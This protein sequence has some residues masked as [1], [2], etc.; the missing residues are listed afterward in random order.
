[1]NML[2]SLQTVRGAIEQARGLPNRF[3]TDAPLFEEEKRRIFANGWSGIGFA[4][5]VP[6]P[7]CVLPIDFLGTPLLAVR[8]SDNHL[9][10]FQNVCRHRGMILV[11]EKARLSKLI[12][13]PYHSWSYD[14]SGK[15][16]A[17]PHVGGS[18]KHEHPAICKAD[19]GLHE[20]RSREF[21]GVIFVNLSG[22]A[23]PFEEHAKTLMTRWQDFDKPLHS[24]GEAGSLSWQV[25]CNWKLVVENY[26]ESYHLPFIH[27]SLNRYSRLEDH[28][29]IEHPG[30]FSGQG[31]RVYAP[32]LTEDGRRL[33]DFPGVGNAWATKGEYIA[34][35]PN[36]LFGVHRDHA[37]AMLLQ[38]LDCGR[39][40]ERLELFYAEDIQDDELLSSN[41][42]LWRTV[43]SEDVMVV[44]GM[45]RG[46]H[47]AAFDGGKFSPVMDGP[48]HVF[49]DWVAGHFV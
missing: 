23:K 33:P 12:R 19:L 44:E 14:F 46:R 31:S 29:H 1:M 36:V 21:R 24:C 11:Q 3:Y 34:L 30:Q 13:C 28:Y 9:R 17:T 22:E 10:V 16:R 40:V 8:D 20:V 6:E 4:A 41:K 39:T 38:P 27:P 32:I 48:T 5:D 25:A 18:G 45:Q 37:F 15:L 7:G 49:H 43:F 2:P 47:C 35:F 26:C 42:E